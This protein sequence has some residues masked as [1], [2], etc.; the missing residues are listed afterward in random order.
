MGNYT[1]GEGLRRIVRR[2]TDK[3]PFGRI[4]VEGSGG[5]AVVKVHT[6]KPDTFNQRRGTDLV[7][8]LE[9]T[10]DR[11]VTIE[12]V[13]EAQARLSNVRVSPNKARRVMDE[14]RGKYVDEALAILQFMPNKA[15]RYVRKLVKSAAA[16]AF[17]GFGADPKEL[18]VAYLVAETGPTM[19]R[20]KP[21]AQG[22]AYRILKRTSHMAVAVQ[23]ADPRPVKG[24]ATRRR[25]SAAV[26][27]A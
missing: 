8:E 23:A 2:T 24:G 25:G 14:V 21:R 7:P 20:V 5:V 3:A 4:T 19:K 27:R 15:A 13:S 26:S 22:R 9:K 10:L 16:N 6:V 12:A 17:E 18:K 1:G 11:A